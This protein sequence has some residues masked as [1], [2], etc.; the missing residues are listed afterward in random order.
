MTKSEAMVAFFVKLNLGT[1]D[2]F[3]ADTVAGV[4]ADLAVIGGVVDKREDLPDMTIVGVLDYITENIDKVHSLT[5]TAT[6][7]TITVTRN[8]EEIEAG[9]PIRDGEKLTITAEADEGAEMSA[10]TVNGESISSGDEIT[11]EGNVVIVG[12]AA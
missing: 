12:T 8:G 2:Q 6:S 10:L 7:C 9:T 11:V 5:V 3:T 1:E 4:L